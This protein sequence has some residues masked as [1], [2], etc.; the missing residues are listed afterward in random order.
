MNILVTGTNGFL[1]KALARYLSKRYN[2]VGL[3]HDRGPIADES[4]H[5][6]QGDI[7]KPKRMLELLVNFEIGTVYHCAARSIVRNCVSDPA[8]CIHTNVYGTA[9]LLEACRQAGVHGVMCM[10]SDKAYGPSDQ[11]YTEQTPLRPT[12]IYEASKACVSH[13]VHTYYHNFGLQ[14]FGVRAANLYGPHDPN[15]SRLVP[16]SLDRLRSGKRPQIIEGAASFVREFLH[17]DDAVWAIT[18]LM[19]AGPWGESVNVGSGITHAIEDAVKIIC[20]TYPGEYQGYDIVPRKAT[21]TEI[22]FQQLYCNRMTQLIKWTP[23]ID[24]QR[25]IELTLEAEVCTT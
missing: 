19:S 21:F 2:V 25:G 17:V 8:G 24:F 9:V 15:R 11:P 13:L 14:V 5:V 3:V 18:H 6:V 12:A 16:H 10:E 1:G 4:Y 22:P 23:A 7:T 20:D